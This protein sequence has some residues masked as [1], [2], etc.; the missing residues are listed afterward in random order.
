MRGRGKFAGTLPTDGGGAWAGTLTTHRIAAHSAA[1]GFKTCR[2]GL[3]ARTG[4]PERAA[5]RGF[6]TVSRVGSG[7]LTTFLFAQPDEVDALQHANRTRTTFVVRC[8]DP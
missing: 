5:R 6:E 3:S 2:C 7:G 4:R 8:H 1:S